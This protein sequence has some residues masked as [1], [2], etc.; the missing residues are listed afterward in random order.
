MCT[1]LG[2]TISVSRFMR[3]DLSGRTTVATV[4]S[5]QKVRNSHHGEANVSL[6]QSRSVVRTVTS[7]SNHLTVCT[8]TTVNNSLHQVVLVLRRRPRQNAQLWPDLVDKILSNLWRIREKTLLQRRSL[9]D[10]SSLSFKSAAYFQ[11]ASVF[12][13]RPQSKASGK[14][15]TCRAHHELN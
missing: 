7:Y 1:V 12:Q 11:S 10:R 3:L 15:E 4:T 5:V 6:L 13:F 2:N 9:W 8:D 14:N